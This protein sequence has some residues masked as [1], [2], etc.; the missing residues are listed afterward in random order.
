ML[1]L[2]VLGDR[3][4]RLFESIL[5]ALTAGVNGGPKAERI[6]GCGSELANVTFG[7]KVGGVTNGSHRGELSG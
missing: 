1:E 4:S 6:R 3:Q 5:S 2:Y 7:L